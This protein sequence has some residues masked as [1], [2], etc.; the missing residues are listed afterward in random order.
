MTFTQSFQR[1]GTN[2]SDESL[3]FLGF[4]LPDIQKLTEDIHLV[5]ITWILVTLLHLISSRVEHFSNN[6][7][8][9]SDM[10]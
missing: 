5:M 9:Y 4:K 7:E 1:N 3:V 8:A 6:N 10:F 2:K